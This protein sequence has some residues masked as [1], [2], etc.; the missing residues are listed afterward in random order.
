M[1]YSKK[2]KELFTKIG[3]FFLEKN[4][5]DFG[6]AQEAIELL[7]ITRI[8][9]S[10]NEMTI[11]LRRPGLLIGKKGER[12]DALSKYLKPFVRTILI[13]EDELVDYLTP[14]DY[15]DF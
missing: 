14:V 9:L 5:G 6:K 8:S 10:S 15:S 3:E 1:G 13:E 2:E 11:C 4:S 12:I 7:G